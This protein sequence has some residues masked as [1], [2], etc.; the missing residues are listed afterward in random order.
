[1]IKPQNR[2]RRRV[3]VDLG[4][5]PVQVDASQGNDTDVNR[6]VARFA[7]TGE[8]PPATVQPQYA[9]VTGLQEDLTVIL[10]RGKDAIA[11]L[12]SIKQQE[13]Q[14]QQDHMD[15]LAAENEKL[16]QQLAESQSPSA[17]PA[18]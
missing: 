16:K 11:E 3:I 13:L 15:N 12:E 1:M 17:S 14:Q 8:L 9:D 10:Q 2:Q 18:E 5:N 7:R 4:E 6:I